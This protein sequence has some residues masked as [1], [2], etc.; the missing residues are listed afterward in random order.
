MLAAGFA[1]EVSNDLIAPA[2]PVAARGAEPA[3]TDSGRKKAASVDVLAIRPRG[4]EPDASDPFATG[5]RTARATPSKAAVVAFKPPAIT[6]P[7]S[8]P[9]LPFRV[10]GRYVDGGEDTVFL[11][12]GEQ[13]MVARVGDVLNEQYKVESISAGVLTL[14]YLPLNQRQTLDIGETPP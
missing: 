6:A 8:I 7:P 14:I 12:F 5:F 4:A 13:N 1:P 3:G 9:A 2:G 11:Q 10:L